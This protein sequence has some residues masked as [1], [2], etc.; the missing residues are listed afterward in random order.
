[1][2]NLKDIDFAIEGEKA[3][4][5]EYAK[6]IPLIEKHFEK[7]DGE[8][9]ILASGDRSA[10][11]ARINREF[12]EDCKDTTTARAFIDSANGMSAWLKIDITLPDT[13]NN[14][15][16]CVYFS[17][18]VPI[19]QIDHFGPQATQNFEYTFNADEARKHVDKILA[20]DAGELRTARDDIAKLQATI[21]KITAAIPYQFKPC[22]IEGR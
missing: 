7:F 17:H 10:A 2:P 4:F 3:L 22:V 12:H 1:M 19:G 11:F 20:A 9:A 15:S 21:E 14:S 18:S 5:T 6:V 13:V 16:G 8:R